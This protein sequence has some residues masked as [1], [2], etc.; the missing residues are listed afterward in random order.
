MLMLRV[1]RRQTGALAAMIG[2]QHVQRGM[3]ESFMSGYQYQLSLCCVVVSVCSAQRPSHLFL[4]LG[5]PPH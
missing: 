4:T 2:R 5:G 3:P 1:V